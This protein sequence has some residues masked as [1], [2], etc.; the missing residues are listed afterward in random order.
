MESMRTEVV[1]IG[2]GPGGYTAAFY[3]ADKGKKVILVDEGK[4][5]GGTCL[6][7]GCIPSKALIHATH[8]ISESR[9]SSKRGITFQDPVI[10]LEKLRGWKGSILQKLSEGIAL[11]AKKRGVDILSGRARFEDATTLRVASKRARPER[12]STPLF[13]ASKA[14]PSDNF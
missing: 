12:I 2:A 1:V 3:A 7:R 6:H 4:R 13:L 14:I 9:E 8:M 5:L 10:D 11:L